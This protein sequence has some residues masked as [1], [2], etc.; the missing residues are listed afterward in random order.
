VFP[1]PSLTPPTLEDFQWSFNGLTM[2]ANT[3][4]G[5]LG[6]EGM[7]M[8]ALRSGDV[9][10]PRDHGQL[11]GLDVY[12]GQ[13]VILDLWVK[14]NGTSLQSSEDELAAATVAQPSE[15]Q[16]LWFQ[17]PNKPLLCL[18]VRPRKKPR[19]I[20]SDYASANIAKPELSLHAEDPRFYGAGQSSTLTLATPTGGLAFPVG[21]PVTFSNITPSTVVLVNGNTEMRPV[22]IFSGPLTNP[23][24]E[25]ASIAGEPFLKVVNPEE[26]GYTVASGDQILLNL[27]TPHLVQYYKGGVASGSEPTDIMEWLTVSSTWWDLLPGA[28]TLRFYSNDATNTGGTATVNWAPAH[29]L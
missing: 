15:D 27:D 22:V 14:S 16:P 19:K 24:I 23:T 13:D 6:A 9:N 17:L 21:F 26:V 8:A 29:A 1:S 18:M 11:K 3:P 10:K 4:F 5:V 12:G 7:N 25:N 20:D 28:N 2:G